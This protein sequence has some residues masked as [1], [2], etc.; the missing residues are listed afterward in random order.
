MAELELMPTPM[1]M[2]GTSRWAVD[3]A[4]TSWDCPFGETGN[5]GLDLISY[6]DAGARGVGMRGKLGRCSACRSHTCV[7]MIDDKDC[8][9]LGFRSA[10]VSDDYTAFAN[11]KSIRSMVG[12]GAAPMDNVGRLREILA[13]INTTDGREFAALEN[14]IQEIV[15]R[16][17][18]NPDG[19]LSIF[20]ETTGRIDEVARSASADLLRVD[21]ILFY[22]LGKRV[23]QDE[24]DRLVREWSNS[25]NRYVRQH[26]VEHWA[27]NRDKQHPF[28]PW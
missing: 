4:H 14:E 20:N 6:E 19:L 27:S 10:G 5:P 15:Y 13:V 26:I 18:C 23:A 11:M 17:V 3:Y 25:Q 12:F 21:A 7:F 22:G 1:P 2:Q 28:P 9:V 16:R 8:L 24:A